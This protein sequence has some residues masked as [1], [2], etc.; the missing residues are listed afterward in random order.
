MDVSGHLHALAALP[1]GE[2]PSTHGKEA[3][4]APERVWTF[5]YFFKFILAYYTGQQISEHFLYL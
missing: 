3:G 5:Y 2:D 1:S 4:W